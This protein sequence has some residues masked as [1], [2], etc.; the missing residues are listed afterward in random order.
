MVAAMA[1]RAP[2]VNRVCAGSG[3]HP[4]RA[5]PAEAA[6]RASG[7]PRAPTCHSAAVRTS[8]RSMPLSPRASRAA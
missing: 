8:A 5:S 3:V 2:A 1:C 4:A 6:A 7:V